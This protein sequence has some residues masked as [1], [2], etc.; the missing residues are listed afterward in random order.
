MAQT[1]LPP[2]LTPQQWEKQK[3]VQFKPSGIGDALKNLQRASAAVDRSLLEVDKLEG[4]AALKQRL[5]QLDAEIAGR[6]KAACDQARSVAAL[7]KK[8]EGEYKKLPQLGKEASAA[9][10]EVAK[11]AAGFGD[12][13]LEAFQAVRK[14]LP[15]RLAK[16]EAEAAKAAAPAD[17]VD[18]KDLKTVRERVLGALRTVK[19]AQPGAKPMQFMVAAGPKRCL[20][21]LGLSVGA[22]HK[23]L[24]GEL[25]A[26]E[27]GIKY[28]RGECVFEAKAYTFV[29]DDIPTGGFGKRLQAGLFEL[30][31]Q[32]FA[33]RIRKSSGEVEEVAGEQEEEGGAGP[34]GA[35]E[36]AKGGDAGAAF[37]RRFAE[38]VARAKA[39]MASAPARAGDLKLK[40]GEAAGLANAG[41]HAKAGRLLDEIEARLGAAGA[42]TGA[43]AK[44]GAGD[45]EFRR[46]WR[47][48]VAGY[49]SASDTV[50]QQI[51][52]LQVKL[53]QS[54][55]AELAQIADKGLN[56]VTGNFKVPLLAVLRD[57]D[58]A[59]GADLAAHARKAAEIA[60]GFVKHLES[61]PT[62]A[63]CDTNPLTPVSIRATLG[64][65]L[66]ELARAAAAAA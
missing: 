34:A 60:A 28:Y 43:G 57:I 41:E 42:G 14:A 12:D 37:Q 33:V 6:L 53:R 25:L 59:S 64:P 32:R 17:S 29:G 63:V 8:W 49:R 9:A 36:G 40:L 61:A 65:A 44:A 47:A 24:L 56:G 48:A 50:D 55:D 13:L 21:Y 10:A 22:S 58:T 31:Q 38:V 26:G 35:G 20:A 11:A 30:T 52:R 16:A 45:D 7:A 62:V 15:A 23:T 27:S 39:A 51:G 46:R 54:G 3:G 66:R 5:A 18:A 1:H 2:V 19:A 4:A